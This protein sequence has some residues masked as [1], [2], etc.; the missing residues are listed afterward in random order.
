MMAP[1]L[2]QVAVHSFPIPVGLTEYSRPQGQDSLVSRASGMVSR[3]G[4]VT[5]ARPLVPEGLTEGS[6]KTVDHW[7]Q[8]LGPCEPQR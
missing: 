4:Q 7:A 2:M 8:N 3:Y 5:G 1:R 6:Q